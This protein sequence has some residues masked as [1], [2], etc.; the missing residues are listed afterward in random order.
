MVKKIQFCPSAH[1]STDGETVVL[2]GSPATPNHPSLQLLSSGGPREWTVGLSLTWPAH[3]EPLALGMPT[4]LS[5]S[6]PAKGLTQACPAQ[7]LVGPVLLSPPLPVVAKLHQKT[8]LLR[9]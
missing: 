1:Y 3:G 2:R 8:P 6:T 9:V 5:L 4:P 7:I